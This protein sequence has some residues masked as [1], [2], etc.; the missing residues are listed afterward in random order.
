MNH[1]KNERDA[2]PSAVTA[3]TFDGVHCGHRAV[4]GCLVEEGLRRGLRPLAL[5]FDP[6]PLAVVA[7]ERAPLLLETPDRRAAAI[8]SLGADVEVLEFT[9]ALRAM[10]AGEWIG[11]LS[12][13]Y[14][15]RLLVV[16]HDNRLGSDGH[17]LGPDDYRRI[18][19]RFG[20]EVV[21]APVV[22]G[23]S[24]TR[25]R[26]CLEQGDV[27]RAGEL[28]GTPFVLEGTVVHGRELGRTL[29]FPTANLEVS[30]MI[31]VPAPG[32]YACSAATASGLCFPAVVNIGRAPTV[33]DSLP[34]TV[35]AHLDGFSGNLY[36]ERLSLMFGDRLR[37]ERRFGSLEELRAQIARD[38]LTLR[39]RGVPVHRP[40]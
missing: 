6:H 25:I 36:G 9:P 29:G 23:V 32:V 11:F 33:G 8:R 16:G 39:G 20:M 7:P 26:R 1:I 37:R 12:R 22:E 30:P 10:S 2:I 38:L 28:L 15:A 4:V 35:E 24:S 5:T 3:G 34:L 40:A 18:G 21:E 19:E 14:G 13:H 27:A 17:S 31:L